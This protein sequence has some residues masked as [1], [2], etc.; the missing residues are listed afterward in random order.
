MTSLKLKFCIM[1]QKYLSLQVLVKPKTK[2][3]LCYLLNQK[4]Q[5]NPE[6]VAT[7]S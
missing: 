4:R 3:Y 5:R 1:L 7:T 6:D 2:P